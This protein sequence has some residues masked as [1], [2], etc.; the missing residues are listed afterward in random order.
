MSIFDCYSCNHNGCIFQMEMRIP[1]VSLLCTKMELLTVAWC[2]QQVMKSPRPAT[3]DHQSSILQTVSSF[4]WYSLVSTATL[5]RP[6]FL[7]LLQLF[8]GDN[9]FVF[10]SLVSLVLVVVWGF[11]LLLLVWSKWSDDLL[12]S[13]WSCASGLMICLSPVSLVLV[14]WGHALLLLVLF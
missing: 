14:V 6:R 12:I 4:Y 2:H 11:T 8:R 3:Q 10:S 5:W 13:C 7:S 1:R 9:H